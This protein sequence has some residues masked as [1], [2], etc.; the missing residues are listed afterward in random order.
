MTWKAISM[1]IS[2][3]LV[4]CCS[5]RAAPAS[6]LTRLQIDGA[7]RIVVVGAE[8]ADAWRLFVARYHRDGALDTAFGN[9]G[10]RFLSLGPAANALL[11][12]ARTAIAIARDGQIVAAGMTASGRTRVFRLNGN[13]TLAS[14]FAL[15]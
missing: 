7:G 13:G 14:S 15:P 9:Q 11:G 3:T 4:G 8:R 5:A 12:Y 10:I 6:R 2:G 1:R